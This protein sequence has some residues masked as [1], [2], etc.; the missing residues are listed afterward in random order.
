MK[1]FFILSLLV[2]M[3][4]SMN[5][6]I[7]SS[8]S[9]ITHRTVIQEPQQ[10]KNYTGWNSLYVEYLPSK[11]GNDSF[12]GAALNYSHAFSLTQKI[13]LY[14]ETGLGGQYSFY[15]K[16]GTKTQFVSAKVPVNVIYEYEIPGTSLSIDPFVGVRLRV[17]IWGDTKFEDY[18][19]YDLFS[20]EGGRCE[21]VQVGWHVG[22]KFRV[23]KV[24]F[25]GGAFGTD[26][27]NFT[28]DDD[29]IKE[30]AVSLGVTF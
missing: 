20:D 18:E 27:M 23:N 10:P 14:L 17:N 13:P 3:S 16:F 7:T 25:I 29:K 22:L 2:A 8:Q 24:F 12:N 5:A 15:K 1:K 21:R 9:S 19:S 30:F 4:M 26:F 28:H 11:L 6:Q